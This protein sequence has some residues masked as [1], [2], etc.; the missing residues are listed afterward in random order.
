MVFIG[1]SSSTSDLYQTFFA[2][3]RLVK[4]DSKLER[5]VN[6]GHDVVIDGYPQPANSFSERAFRFAQGNT[7][8]T[9]HYLHTLLQS[10]RGITFDLSCLVIN[11]RT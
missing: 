6:K 8:N 9:A 7:V 1:A 3:R 5:L 2:I 11:T 4:G 10:L